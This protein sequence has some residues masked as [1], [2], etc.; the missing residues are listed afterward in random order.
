MKRYLFALLFLAVLP[1]HS[2]VLNQI[3]EM[4]N[5]SQ[6]DQNN[7]NFNPHNN[8]TTKKN[9][10]IPRGIHVW[11]IDRKFG[12]IRPVEVDTMP[13]LYMNTTLN[14]GVYGEYNTTGNNYTARLNRIYID[15]PEPQQFMFN[16]VY[17]YVNKAP[18]ELHFTNTLS[19]LTNLSYD[20]CGDKQTGEDHLQ[21]KF[22]VNAGK[23]IGLGFDLN[24]A[25]ARG[26][27]SNQA[28]SHFG[29]LFYGSYL[30]DQY[31]MHLMFSTY[32][33]KAAENGGITNDEYIVHPESIEQTFSE[34]EIPTV[35]SSTWNRNDNLHLFLTH[36]YNIGFYRKVKMTEEEIKARQFAQASKKAQ[37]KEKDKKEGREPEPTFSGRPKDAAIAGK[38]PAREKPTLPDTTRITVDSQEVMDSLL[39][40]E[41]QKEEE[42]M[43]STMKKEF[44]PVTSIIHTAE[45]NKYE[46]IFMTYGSPTDYYANTY[47]R[48]D[49]TGTKDS[50]YDETHHLQIKNTV[51]LALLEGFNKWVKSGLKIFAT[52]EMRNFKMDE[53][54]DT[55]PVMQK[56]TEQ[57]FS[58]GGQ[59]IKSQGKTFHYN[60]QA[61]LWTVGEDA[62]QLKA[63]FN[64]DLNF[65]VFGDTVTLA[66]HAHFHRL[67]PTY[68]QRHY[69]S[70]HLWWDNDN[71][72]KETHTRIEG[73]FSYQKTKTSLRVAIEEIMN[74]TYIGMSY[75]YSDTGRKYLTANPEQH[76]GNINVLTAQ[77]KQHFKL[78][79]INWE[80]VIT[81]QNSSNQSVLPVPM[82]NVFTNLYL[83]FKIAKVLTV[84]LGADATYFTEYDAP[85]FCPQLN[86][87][88]I[89]QNDDS[90]IKL[91]NF[92]FIDVYANMHLKRARFFVM[93]TNAASSSFN[94]KTFLTPHYPTDSSVLRMGVSW[95]FFN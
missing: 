20:N 3:D 6:Y 36:R 58:I 44:V 59:L 81:Y 39:M 34:N 83:G 25:Y 31:N 41:K 18:D 84:E 71:L 2:Q 55:L 23:R 27:F 89:Q 52:H 14:T 13:H 16:E 74:Y 24:Y 77:L 61:E 70:K 68:Y 93:M 72:D 45:L 92:P 82:L 19:P 79:P 73:L 46:R 63:S 94:R 67:N 66:A 51:A 76:G 43:D 50:I 42:E 75:V 35:L 32:H 54:Q 91:G 28:A 80:N 22:A 8:D 78:G 10:E 90:R 5:I 7:Q 33:Q 9:K 53:L 56:V 65:P 95:N 11:T 12:D 88:A 62:G 29:G 69:H 86:Q 26:Y 87:Y 40:V 48:K 38:E 49:K 17:S 4:G 1:A 30:G 60:A 64:T 57:N 47:F 85:D 15:R 21:A 37:Q